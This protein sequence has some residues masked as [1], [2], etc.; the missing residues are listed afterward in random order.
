MPPSLDADPARAFARRC[1]RLFEFDAWAMARVFDALATLPAAPPT[2]AVSRIEHITWAAE[3][4]LTRVQG[5]ASPPESTLRGIGLQALRLRSA[6]SGAA[7]LA[8][9]R[10]SSD[11]N[12]ARL[13][14][15]RNTKG[16]EFNNTVGDI[17]TH[18]VNHATYHRGQ[19]ATDLKG[20]RPEPVPTD[21]IVF[22]RET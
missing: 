21:F 18:V 5:V 3:L 13:V 22:A 12:L 10:S 19:L 6:T 15:Y 11:A 17:I 1:E 20:L 9:A 2:Q 16:L 7:W 4:W 8:I 14:R